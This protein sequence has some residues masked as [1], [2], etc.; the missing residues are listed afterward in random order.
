MIWVLVILIALVVIVG[1]LLALMFHFAR[2]ALMGSA[3]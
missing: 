3:R 2:S 1:G